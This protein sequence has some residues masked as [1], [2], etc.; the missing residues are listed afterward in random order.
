MLW[1]LL[2]CGPPAELVAE[3][4]QLSAHVEALEARVKTTEQERDAWKSRAES[5]QERLDEQRV[6]E[7]HAR[8][9]LSG[10]E[11]LQAVLETSMGDLHCTLWPDHAPITVLNFVELAEGSR[12]W[13]D[14]RTGLDMDRRYYDGTTF[15]RVIPG[16]MIQ[17]GD[18]LG[19]GTGGPGY[20]FED[21]IVPGLV[22]DRPGLL[23]MANA[24]PNTNGS[25]FFVTQAAQPSLNGRHTIFGECEELDLVGEIA[26]VERDSKDKPI[27]PVVLR[28]VTIT[29]G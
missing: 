17:G 13:Q 12:T 28:R 4:D 20:K 23:A 3:R 6:R 22:F 18:P 21:E 11:G 7:T 8:L 1:T 14:P 2:S 29:R 25:Q 24:G 10:D 9:G 16:F 5:L 15:H 26:S 19:N 27:E